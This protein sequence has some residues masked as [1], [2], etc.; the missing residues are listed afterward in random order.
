MNTENIRIATTSTRTGQ[1]RTN[2]T[3]REVYLCPGLS[4]T[5][6]LSLKQAGLLRSGVGRDQAEVPVSELGGNPASRGARQEPD[7]DQV[8]LV[9]ILDR[10]RFLR[11]GGG[12]GVEPNRPALELE[13]QRLQKLAVERLQAQLVD[14]EHAQ[15]QP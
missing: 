2:C 8:G 7:L 9:H 1:L 14:L 5:N 15:R 12:N 13:D 11:E 4:R 3:A 10:L 6:P